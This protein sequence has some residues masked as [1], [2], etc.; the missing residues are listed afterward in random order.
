MAIT[1]L[2]DPSSRACGG[3]AVTRYAHMGVRLQGVRVLLVL[4]VGLVCG[5]CVAVPRPSTCSGSSPGWERLSS[6]DPWSTPLSDDLQAW[7]T[8]IGPWQNG[9][10]AETRSSCHSV[11]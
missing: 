6:W 11:K 8:G 7:A 3:Q 4:N 1:G 2:G 9:G 10:E 5:G